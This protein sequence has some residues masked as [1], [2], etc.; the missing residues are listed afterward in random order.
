MGCGCRDSGVTSGQEPDGV[1]HYNVSVCYPEENSPAVSG[2]IRRPRAGGP[3]A[4]QVPSAATQAQ[5]EN[6]EGRSTP[7]QAIPE[8]RN[9]RVL[10]FWSARG[11]R[12]R[13]TTSGC[14]ASRRGR[15]VVQGGSEG[16]STLPKTGQNP[17]SLGVVGFCPG[18]RRPASVRHGWVHDGPESRGA[19]S[20]GRPESQNPRV[21]GF[22]PA[23]GGR[24]R[25]GED[26]EGPVDPP[27][28]DRLRPV[29]GGCM[30]DRG[31][32]CSTSDP[33]R[34][35]RPADPL[36]TGR[37]DPNRAAA[38]APVRSQVW[39]WVRLTGQALPRPGVRRKRRNRGGSGGQRRP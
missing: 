31:R 21:L 6:S 36:G 28:A 16:R 1:N 17:R 7:S 38:R 11:N 14:M 30:T 23:R 13:S 10:G 8:S 2:Y 34:S 9:P 5:R 3:R 32:E 20:P 37:R 15:R 18:S 33:F 35:A 39:R 24:G 26:G 12:L 4:G 19:P 25:R 29:T 27:E 22:C